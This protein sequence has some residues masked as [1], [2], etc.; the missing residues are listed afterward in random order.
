MG[1]GS[2][3]LRSNEVSVVGVRVED[4]PDEKLATLLIHVLRIC[5]G[6]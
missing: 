6:D 4:L 3:E 5:A 2:I 1:N